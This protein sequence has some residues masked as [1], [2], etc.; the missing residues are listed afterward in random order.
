MRSSVRCSSDATPPEASVNVSV[1]GAWTIVSDGSSDV[2]LI[3]S[4]SYAT[5]VSSRIR[6]LSCQPCVVRLFPDH[7]LTR[8]RPRKGVLRQ[9]QLI[10]FSAIP[11]TSLRISVTAGAVTPVRT[12]APVANGP[13]ERRNTNCE[14]AP[15]V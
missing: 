1:I 4:G 3:R 6:G 12:P 13:A 5:T 7:A 2:G 14:L 10:G 15:Y 8:Q 11:R 9:S